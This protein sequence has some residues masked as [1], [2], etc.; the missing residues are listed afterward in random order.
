MIPMTTLTTNP[1]Q[2]C[3]ISHSWGFSRLFCGDRARQNL[4]MPELRKSIP[5]TQNQG[6][7]FT[8]WNPEWGLKDP[9]PDIELAS[10]HFFLPAW[11]ATE[12]DKPFSLAAPPVWLTASE[13]HGRRGGI[14]LCQVAAMNSQIRQDLSVN[15]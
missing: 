13:D 3:Q 9:A 7:N 15:S 4:I 11:V 8:G 14:N 2:E 12:P 1:G 5:A 10:S 6:T